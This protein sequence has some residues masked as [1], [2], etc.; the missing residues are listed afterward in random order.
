MK[1]HL[2]SGLFCLLSLLLRADAVTQPAAPE[3][4]VPKAGAELDYI[5][6]HSDDFL[7]HYPTSSPG[8][9][10]L[11]QFVQEAP[12]VVWSGLDHERK[13]TV[14]RTDGTKYDYEE[15]KAVI[16]IEGRGLAKPEE[17]WMKG[18]RVITVTWINDKLIF[19]NANIS[20]VTN[21]QAIYDVEKH[22]WIYRESVQYLD[23]QPGG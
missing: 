2:L 21:V 17:L 1:K 13:V 7:D 20:H 19:I 4:S 12:V 18:F 3:P 5:I 15:Q 6:V 22:V 16:R 11:S 14:Y 9:F 10:D 8:G 23:I